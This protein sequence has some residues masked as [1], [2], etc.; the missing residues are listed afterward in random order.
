MKADKTE[1]LCCK[2]IFVVQ[3]THS[4]TEL[5]NYTVTSLHVVQSDNTDG[6]NTSRIPS[7]AAAA[8]T[9][10]HQRPHSH[11]DVEHSG[12]IR[13]IANRK[14]AVSLLAASLYIDLPRVR[15]RRRSETARAAWQQPP[16]REPATG[17][18]VPRE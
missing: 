14:R 17:P 10:Q 8:T 12:C 5:C 6:F 4:A 13:A 18:V 11:S 7:F 15:S 3:A 9:A 2:V 16:L 1:N